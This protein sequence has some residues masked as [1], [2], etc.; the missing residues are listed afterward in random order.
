MQM[1]DVMIAG[2]YDVVNVFGQIG[3][4]P[5]IR[6]AAV[7]QREITCD[8]K[9]IGRIIDNIVKSLEWLEE[10]KMAGWLWA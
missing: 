8:N 5:I 4:D 6:L 2:H 1:I 9:K 10:Q 3:F 7:R